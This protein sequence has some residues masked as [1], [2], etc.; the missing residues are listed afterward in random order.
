M[1]KKPKKKELSEYAIDPR[2]K[3]VEPN[4]RIQIPE[5]IAWARIIAEV[6]SATR[7]FLDE[8]EKKKKKRDKKR[9]GKK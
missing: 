5:L 6:A 4:L 1:F 8:E 7:E 2:G 3:I 9:G